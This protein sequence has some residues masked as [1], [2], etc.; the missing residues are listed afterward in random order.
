MT[1]RTGQD[2]L[3]REL[4]SEGLQKKRKREQGRFFRFQKEKVVFETYLDFTPYVKLKFN[5]V[6]DTISED[7]WR[8]E[9]G[10]EEE[11]SRFILSD[12]GGSP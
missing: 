2:S 4:E 6:C 7:S 5:A 8:E 3:P 11:R 10:K 1:C 12:F 9:E